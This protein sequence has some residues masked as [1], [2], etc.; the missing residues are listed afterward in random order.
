MGFDVVRGNQILQKSI[1]GVAYPNTT[2]KLDRTIQALERV[3]CSFTLWNYTPDNCEES[4]DLWNDEDLSIYT[5]AAGKGEFNAYEGGRC[6][7]AVIRPYVF[8][9]AGICTT[10][11][12][13]DSREFACEIEEE[14][15]CSLRETVVFVPN[16]QYPNGMEVTISNGSY[17]WD[18]KEQTLLWKHGGGFKERLQLQKKDG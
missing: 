1:R 6:L 11:F 17:E 5:G 16:Y 2:P 10:R 13:L 15:C 4:G 7:P 8:K 12:D 18:P 3:G 14:N 9:A